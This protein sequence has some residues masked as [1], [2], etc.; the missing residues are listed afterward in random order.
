MNIIP[1]TNSIIGD[2]NQRVFLRLL[3]ST[4]FIFSL[5]VFSLHGQNFNKLKNQSWMKIMQNDTSVN[6]F[7][8]QKDYS[9]FKKAYKKEEARKEE[10]ERRNQLKHSRPNEPHLEN[11][12]ENIMMAYENWERS[13]KPFVT[14]DGKVMP[15]E[16][17]LKMVLKNK[18]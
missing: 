5:S 12:E 11:P 2:R 9:K 7:K 4:L 10:R 16:Q 1:V 18:E 8:A 15:V 13:M 17:R 14:K 6:F 3:S